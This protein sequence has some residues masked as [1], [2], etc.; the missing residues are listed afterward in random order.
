MF[1]F[2]WVPPLTK[3]FLL[4]SPLSFKRN[5]LE[6]SQGHFS[7]FFFF[8]LFSVLNCV[9]FFVIPWTVT[10][11]VLCPWDFPGTNTGMDCHFLLQGI[12][13]RWDLCLLQLLHWEADS[14][15]LRHLGSCSPAIENT[16]DLSCL[17]L[18]FWSSSSWGDEMLWVCGLV[19]FSSVGQS[20]PTLCNPMGCSTPGLPVHHQFPEF[21][22]THVHWISDA[23]QPSHPLSSPSPPA[24]NL[25]QHQGLFKWV[26][27]SHQVAKVLEFQLQHQSFQW[28]FRT[29]FL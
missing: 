12:F 9:Q 19:Q 2:L 28:I 6:R 24:F 7:N 1:C 29:D 17:T 11:R 20:C 13:Q 22:Q 27:S 3:T 25:S 18:S 4:C 10:R 23:I 8:L 16:Y 14:L 26:S 15:P 5:C 21:T